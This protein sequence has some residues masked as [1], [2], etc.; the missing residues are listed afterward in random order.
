MLRAGIHQGNLPPI[1]E[2]NRLLGEWQKED[3]KRQ[4]PPINILVR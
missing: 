4:R 1:Q 2:V 3:L